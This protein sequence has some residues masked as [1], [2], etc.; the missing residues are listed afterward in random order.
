MLVIINSQEDRGELNRI[1]VMLKVSTKGMLPSIESTGA[2]NTTNNNPPAPTAPTPPP[3][4]PQTTTNKMKMSELVANAVPYNLSLV[5]L[6]KEE[7]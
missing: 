5:P 6:T 4:I 3:T 1:R 2:M 7:K